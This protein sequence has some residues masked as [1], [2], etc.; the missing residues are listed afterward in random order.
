MTSITFKEENIKI[1]QSLDNNK[2]HSLHEI[3]ARKSLSIISKN[4]TKFGIFPE[5]YEK[6]NTCPLHKKN[7]K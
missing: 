1:L 6:L 5:I 3:S 4:C 2:K 7:E